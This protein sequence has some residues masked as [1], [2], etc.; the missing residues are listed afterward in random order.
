M[1]N[2]YSFSA[3]SMPLPKPLLL[4]E[5]EIG[6]CII[7]DNGLKVCAIGYDSQRYIVEIIDGVAFGFRHQQ[8]IQYNPT[9]KRYEINGPHLIKWHRTGERV[10]SASRNII[11]PNTNEFDNF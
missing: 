11:Q 3:M 2:R 5:V 1:G 6:D 4:G 7:S 10:E 9:L 8:E